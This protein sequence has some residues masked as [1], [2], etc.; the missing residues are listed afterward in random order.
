MAPA[1]GRTRRNIP[2]EISPHGQPPWRTGSPPAAPV[3]DI[4]PRPAPA[5]P[6]RGRASRDNGPRPGRRPRERAHHQPR[7]LNPRQ[8]RLVVRGPR[9][10]PSRPGRSSPH[11]DVRP[12]RTEVEEDVRAAPAGLAEVPAH[13]LTSCFGLD[14]RGKYAPPRPGQKRLPH[15]RR[16]RIRRIPAPRILRTSA[17]MAA[18]TPS[19]T[20]PATSRR[21][22]TTLPR[23][24]KRFHRPRARSAPS[25]RGGP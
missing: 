4:A 18:S 13:E 2:P 21:E 23:P 24:S 16:Y 25:P 3:T 9:P 10:A 15:R 12:G 8:K 7:G 19:H 11:T 20:A 6:G 5:G 17:P 1:D 14:W 22:I